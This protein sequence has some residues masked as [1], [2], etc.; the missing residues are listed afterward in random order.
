MKRNAEKRKE[1]E[2]QTQNK[3]QMKVTKW[4]LQVQCEGGWWFT[5][6]EFMNYTNAMLQQM[7]ETKEDIIYGEERR[8][9][10]IKVTKTQ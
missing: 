7:T 6:Q 3:K 4:A 10:I 9:Q 1:P 5:I 2:Q 8:Y